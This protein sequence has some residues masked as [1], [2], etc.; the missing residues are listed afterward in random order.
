MS[1]D[2]ILQYL[3]HR[4]ERLA[5]LE[6]MWLDPKVQCYNDTEMPETGSTSVFLN[7]P[8]SRRQI[9]E[10]NH[11]CLSVNFL[12]KAGYTGWIFVPEPRGQEE[13]GD[14]T[15]KGRIHEWE[16][17][18]RD[19]A[20]CNSFWIPR[21]S[22]EMLALNTNLELGINVGQMLYDNATQLTVVGWPPDAER[23]GLP[24]HYCN[25]AEIPI[26]HDQNEM[27]RYIAH[28]LKEK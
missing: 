12:R 2:R 23:M 10:F 17:S 3:V 6:A 21:D 16:S 25:R 9:L 4:G 14:F 13:Q 11:R 27:C 7:G 15:E 18:R 19:S 8:T 28:R 5:L 1:T 22:G 20:S 26:F 24:N